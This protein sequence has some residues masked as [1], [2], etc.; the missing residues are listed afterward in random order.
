MRDGDN[1]LFEQPARGVRGRGKILHSAMKVGG[2]F[3]ANPTRPAAETQ[4]S[5]QETQ[6]VEVDVSESPVLQ[7]SRVCARV[8]LGRRPSVG[9]QTSV[10]HQKP[11]HLK[12]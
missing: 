10:S 8:E 6:V 4:R 12:N 11:E 2:E 7:I 9:T 5:S 1:L 3:S